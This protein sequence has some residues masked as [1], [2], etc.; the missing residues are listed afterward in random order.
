MNPGL[1]IKLRRKALRLTQQQCAFMAGMG[2]SY[3]AQIETGKANVNL[4][5]LERI[6][7]ALQCRPGELLGERNG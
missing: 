1:A 4:K 5:T 6:A 3:W 2:Q 7:A